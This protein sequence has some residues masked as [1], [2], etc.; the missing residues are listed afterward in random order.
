M[1]NILETCI[2][3]AEEGEK[4]EGERKKHIEEKEEIVQTEGPIAKIIA[5]AI[6]D[7]SS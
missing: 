1:Y 2:Q 5:D 4:N 3:Y 7:G 6:K